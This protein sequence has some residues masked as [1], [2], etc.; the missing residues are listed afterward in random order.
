MIDDPLT[1][2]PD[3]ASR[4]VG[5]AQGM[6]GLADQ[7]QSALTMVMNF[8]FV[9]GDFK[10][11]TLSVL[12]RNLVLEGVR[13]MPVVGGTGAFRFA[14]GYAQARTHTSDPTGDAVVKYDVYVSHADSSMAS[15][16]GAPA[17]TLLFL[18]TMVMVYLSLTALL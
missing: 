11:S 17:C 13:E 15:S 16:N 2:G 6:Y 1:D 8:V 7:T 10:G 5:R 12:G 18:F 14:K 9:E 3:P 4:L